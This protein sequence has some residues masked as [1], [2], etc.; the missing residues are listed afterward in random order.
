MERATR[1]ELATASL[2][3]WSST[4]ELRPLVPCRSGMT[5]CLS[6]SPCIRRRGRAHQR[7]L[8]TAQHEWCGGQA[9]IRPLRGSKKKY[10]LSKIEDSCHSGLIAHTNRFPGKRQRRGNPPPSK[11]GSIPLN[12]NGLGEPKIYQNNIVYEEEGILSSQFQ[13]FE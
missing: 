8:S 9:R 11:Y 3:G 4:P 6:K 7:S 2:E 13:G 12:L 1:F 5:P 10:T